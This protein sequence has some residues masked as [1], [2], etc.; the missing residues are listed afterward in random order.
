MSQLAVAVI[1]VVALAAVACG[2]GGD[3]RTRDS[4]PSSTTSPAK[5]STASAK[6]GDEV[7]L[8]T[9]SVALPA[10]NPPRQ[11]IAVT[12]MQIVD[13]AP[14]RFGGQAGARNVGV[15][16]RYVNRGSGLYSD[17]VLTEVQLFDEAGQG[18]TATVGGTEAGPN[19]PSGSVRL[20]PGETALGF[21]GFDV[22]TASKIAKVRV[23]LQAGVG[24]S[25]DWTV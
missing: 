4:E 24:S 15:Q 7:T 22:P 14:V 11:P 6:V 13:P 18:F 5:P 12:V 19:F 9:G 8:T 23:T 25:A 20:N 3:Q 1:A 17:S 16:L 21:V 10:G 2:N